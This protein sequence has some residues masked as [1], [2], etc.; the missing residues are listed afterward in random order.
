MRSP[1]REAVGRRVGFVVVAMHDV[2]ACRYRCPCGSPPAGRAGYSVLRRSRR[3]KGFCDTTRERPPRQGQGRALFF[4]KRKK[5]FLPENKTVAKGTTCPLPSPNPT[6]LYNSYS[7]V[8]FERARSFIAEHRATSPRDSR[9]A[10]CCP[11]KSARST[12]CIDD[13][14]FIFSCQ[15]VCGR[16][17]ASRCRP[18]VTP[19]ARLCGSRLVTVYI[20]MKSIRSAFSRLAFRLRSC[21]IHPE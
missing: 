3:V 11:P 13:A 16:A 8:S 9:P 7:R 14:D 1:A 12:R 17:G 21:A 15:Q 4:W 2:L 20:L 19:L 10:S 6:V 18:F 5:R